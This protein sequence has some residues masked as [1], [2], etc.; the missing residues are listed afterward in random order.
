VNIDHVKRHYY[1]SHPKV[2]PTRIVPLGPEL[3]FDAPHDRSKFDRK[4]ATA[5]RS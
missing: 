5:T 3:N 1:G 4:R 2:N